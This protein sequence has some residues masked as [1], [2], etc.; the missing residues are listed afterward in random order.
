MSLQIARRDET[1]LDLPKPFSLLDE[2]TDHEQLL[3][4]VAELCKIDQT[5]IEDVYP[6]SH[7]Q[8]GLIALSL[9]NPGAYIVD[10]VFAVPDDMETLLLE[11]ACSE[12]VKRNS[13][14]RTR[15]VHTR[16]GFLQVIL[17]HDFHW[18]VATEATGPGS[19]T[20]LGL[21][22]PLCRFK[23]SQ[24]S[25]S[26]RFLTW[27]LHHALYDGWSMALLQKQ[28]EDFFMGHDIT[29]T[30]PYNYFIR[31][32]RS[33]STD[34]VK[35]FW[36]GRLAGPSPVH[37][38]KSPSTSY[39][40]RPNQTIEKTVTFQQ[41]FAHNVAISNFVQAAWA[42][43]VSRHTE[44]KNICLG[45][46]VS[47]RK[48]DLPGIE[49]VTGPTF[50]TVPA[51]VRLHEE[52]TKSTLLQR[53]QAEALDQIHFEQAGLSVISKFTDET[54]DAC[55]FQTLFVVQ[56]VE[57]DPDRV[58]TLLDVSAER[59]DVDTYP[60]NL[61]CQLTT[62]GLVMKARFDSQ[63]ISEFHVTHLLS[64]FSH[65]MKQLCL[66]DDIRVKDIDTLSPEDIAQIRTW[67]SVALNPVDECL[68]DLILAK[69]D[70]TPA[71]QAICA[72]DG[73]FTY[74][75]MKD[76]TETIASN[77]Q[78]KGVKCGNIVPI[79]FD[80]SRWA[81][82]AMLGVLRAGAAC[83]CLDP[84]NHPIARMRTIVESV[85]ARIIVCDPVH[86]DIA[87]TLTSE[88]LVVGMGAETDLKTNGATTPVTEAKADD[89][90][91]LIY[92]SGSTGVP[93]GMVHTHR[94]LSSSYHALGAAIK[95][96]CEWFS[97]R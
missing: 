15:I 60:L 61:E 10:D 64:Q 66:P 55:A 20:K 13:I 37:F 38:P 42:I 5:I 51:I 86:R 73:N 23:V 52:D 11:R 97:P 21:G 79:F 70:Q 24:D 12:V 74:Q 39:L 65:V 58:H 92:T 69:C 17:R 6:C 84:V 93:K 26:K 33:L 88:V 32:A 25:Q 85:D 46:T 71:A 54:R 16:Q 31:H 90:A 62:T 19:P 36:S 57:V 89:A 7:L 91:F 8:E 81:V 67:N 44:S 1:R 47:G 83:V 49:S 2:N 77:L 29:P 48:V 27:T 43:A 3:A 30:I 87:M 40:A 78:S 76:W 53:L 56:P 63:L 59:S 68:H 72:W 14:L 94:S 80:K 45:T 75:E 9:K 41:E 35:N 95:L 18:Q 50:A 4:S 22:E 28:L 34:A 82:V 96:R